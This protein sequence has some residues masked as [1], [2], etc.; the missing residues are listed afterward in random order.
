MPY[1]Q[2][3]DFGWICPEWEWGVVDHY[4]TSGRARLV[5]AL[6]CGDIEP[7]YPTVKEV[8]FRCHLCGGCDM[9]DKRNLELRAIDD[10]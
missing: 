2:V 10:A 9:A 5:N 6:L 3:Y 4:G 1:L 7:E 8:A